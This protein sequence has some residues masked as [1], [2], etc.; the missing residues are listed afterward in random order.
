MRLGPGGCSARRSQADHE[1]LQV[2]P[3]KAAWRRHKW[4]ALS[5]CQERTIWQ[6]DLRW[7]AHHG[8]GHEGLVQVEGHWVGHRVDGCC[9]RWHLSSREHP[10]ACGTVRERGKGRHRRPGKL[11]PGLPGLP[12]GA[13]SGRDEGL[14][15]GGSRLQLLWLGGQLAS[16]PQHC[17]H[18]ACRVCQICTASMTPCV[19]LFS[20]L[21]TLMTSLTITAL[22]ILS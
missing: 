19:C 10:H 1:P 11:H 9:V 22:A 7:S 6:G 3:G 4:E 15:N 2:S 16:G 20:A 17:I 8:C 21:R 5:V 13:C 12:H 14:L 18:L